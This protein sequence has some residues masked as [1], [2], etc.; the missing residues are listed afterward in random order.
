MNTKQ[1]EETKLSYIGYIRAARAGLRSRNGSPPWPLVLLLCCVS[2]PF[3]YWVHQLNLI[4]SIPHMH[5]LTNPPTFGNLGSGCIHRLSGSWGLHTHTRNPTYSQEELVSIHV[6]TS[7]GQTNYDKFPCPP[8]CMVWVCHAK[9]CQYCQSG[10][11]HKGRPG[12][13]H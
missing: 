1:S 3:F 10:R 8:H 7:G 13:N 5:R 11:L 2:C 9:I 4:L 6:Q 12:L